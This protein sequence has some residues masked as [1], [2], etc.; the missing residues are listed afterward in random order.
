MTTGAIIGRV[1]LRSVLNRPAPSMRAAS[2]RES[3]TVCSPAMYSTRVKPNP[4][5]TTTAIRLASAHPGWD[6]NGRPVCLAERS[7]VLTAPLV[8]SRADQR[9]PMISALM[10]YG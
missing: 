7:S 6:R 3:G 1:T 4:D 2:S 8:D 5:Q 10:T 9:K